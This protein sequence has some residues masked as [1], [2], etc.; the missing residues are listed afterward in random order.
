MI[1]MIGY[2]LSTKKLHQMK[3]F[4][5]AQTNSNTVVIDKLPTA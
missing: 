5:F 4:H 2:R 3:D 1:K